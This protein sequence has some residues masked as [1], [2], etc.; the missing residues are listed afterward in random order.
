MREKSRNKQ[1]RVIRNDS[2]LWHTK[3]VVVS[4]ERVRDKYAIMGVKNDLGKKI[5]FQQH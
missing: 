5:L 3:M 4:W 2:C 1:K